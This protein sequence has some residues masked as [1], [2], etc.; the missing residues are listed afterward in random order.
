MI[1]P[2]LWARLGLLWT[3]AVPA[4]RCVPLLGLLGS[5]A[6]LVDQGPGQEACPTCP[7]ILRLIPPLQ[8]AHR[9]ASLSPFLPGCPRVFGTWSLALSLASY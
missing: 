5:S 6:L 7:A 3:A 8:P 2:G 9:K 1:L 4:Q